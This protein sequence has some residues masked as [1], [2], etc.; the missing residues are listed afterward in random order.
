MIDWEFVAMARGCTDQLSFPLLGYGTKVMLAVGTF[1]RLFIEDKKQLIVFLQMNSMLCH[2]DMF[3]WLSGPQ[4]SWSSVQWIPQ[5]FHFD[6]YGWAV[7]NFYTCV[8]MFSLASEFTST[9]GCAIRRWPWWQSIILCSDSTK[10]PA[11]VKGKCSMQSWW[12]SPCL[13]MA[14]TTL[15]GRLS[16]RRWRSLRD[17]SCIRFAGRG[18]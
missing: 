2:I 9:V 4:I 17:E 8:L 13:W 7:L 6:W 15:H 14:S 11:C 10:W 16:C 18:N 3:S 1:H 12:T 5:L